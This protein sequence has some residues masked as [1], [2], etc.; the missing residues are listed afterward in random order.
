[1]KH[2]FLPLFCFLALFLGACSRLAPV[3]EVQH[4]M[5]DIHLEASDV[6]NAILLAAADMGWKINEVYKG[7]FEAVLRV[8]SHKAVARIH[9]TDLTYVIWYKDSEN[10]RATP[11]GQIH[12]NYNVWVQRLD[13]RIQYHLTMILTEKAK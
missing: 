13:Q 11:D 8:R 7:D 10:L 5:S 3:Y 2:V 9:Y 12:R 1:M 4:T 6:R